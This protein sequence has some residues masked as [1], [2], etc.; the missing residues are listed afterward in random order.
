MIDIKRLSEEIIKKISPEQVLKKRL[1]VNDLSFSI[2]NIS[3]DILNFDQIAIV[4]I[5]KASSLF[6]DTLYLALKNSNAISKKLI[7]GIVATKYEHSVFSSNFVSYESAH[8]IPDDNSILSAKHLIDYI[9]GL[10]KNTLLVVCLSGGASS[11][12]DF[13]VDGFSLELNGKL[14]H[15]LL[16]N[17]CPVEEMNRLRREVSLIKNGG[18][19]AMASVDNILVLAI[20]DVPSNDVSLIGSGPFYYEYEEDVSLLVDITN[21][22]VKMDDIKRPLINYLQSEARKELLH[23][24]KRRLSTKE[25]RHLIISDFYHLMSEA[26][27]VIRT[28]S[29]GEV[30]VIDTPLIGRIDNGVNEH[31]D[32][33]AKWH[34]KVD[35]LITGG[36]YT[37]DLKGNGI[38]G[39]NMEF[40]LRLGDQLFRHKNS[41]Y[42][43]LS[44]GTDGTD[45]PTDYAGS[46]LNYNTYHEALHR[47]LKADVF[48]NDNDSLNYF[49]MNN[50]LIKT[51]PTHTNVM[52]LR[53]I[54][55]RRKN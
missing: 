35:Y 9:S 17:A 46:F 45:G 44:I 14:G 27:D 53:I 33:I 5:G 15:E 3:Y 24:R 55:F 31:L 41:N 22:Y 54:S 8:P 12:I 2:D 29:G 25:I 48:I 21:R 34:D 26:R 42:E 50:G 6:T 52:D 38:G 36:E 13:P 16:A 11:I 47:G 20:S 19:A 39:R 51:G 43:I 23:E 28:F 30:K 1:S 49:M 37:V 7:K 32:L 4:G 40:V 10:S 18:L